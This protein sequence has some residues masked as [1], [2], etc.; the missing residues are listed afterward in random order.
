MKTHGL[1]EFVAQE[2]MGRY[3]GYWW[4]P[5][6]Q[7]HRLRGGRPHR[8]RDVVRR[9]PARSPTRSRR[10]S[11]TRGRAR[12][13]SRCGSASCRS[14]GGE[15]VW[16]EWDREEVRVPGGGASG[17]KRGPLDDSRCRTGKQQEFVAAAGRS[18]DRQDDDSC[19]TRDG[20]GLGEP[21]PGRAALAARAARASS[22]WA[23]MRRA[24]R[25]L[26]QSCDTTTA[27][28]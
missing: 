18:D 11:S 17:T 27:S 2:E 12:R 21:A 4:S 5:D 24:N 9:R 26:Q 6:A 19:S 22:G 3:S 7:A 23:T 25:E 28:S 14:S 1:A 15:T 20:R 8:R 16:V 13:T 10:S